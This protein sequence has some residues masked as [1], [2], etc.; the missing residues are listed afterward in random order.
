MRQS[1]G[2]AFAPAA[3][4]PELDEEEALTKMPYATTAGLQS[5]RQTILVVDDNDDIRTYLAGLLQEEF[6]V[7]EAENGSVGHKMA[8]EAMP[9]LI[10][11][12]VMM[13][14]MNGLQLLTEVRKRPEWVRV[15][16]I[17]LTALGE[18]ED[19]L[20]GKKLGVDD[21]LHKP[22]DAEAYGQ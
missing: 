17:F 2:K 10:I 16:F 7:L 4:N 21:Y 22:F 13:P 1:L 11:S 5:T 9:D 3:D 8:L 6:E 19:V 20:L 15:P 14:E 12:D 18:R